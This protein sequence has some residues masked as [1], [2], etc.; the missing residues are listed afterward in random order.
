MLVLQ[1]FAEEDF[2][3]VSQRSGLLKPSYFLLRDQAIGAIVLLIRGTQTVKVGAVIHRHQG[4]HPC[5]GTGSVVY[6]RQLEGVMSACGS[7]RTT[8]NLQRTRSLPRRWWRVDATHFRSQRL[9]CAM[10]A[11]SIKL[12]V[13][14]S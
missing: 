13:Q 2:L 6:L 11:N 7:T 1:G 5:S 8:S 14:P 4:C 12:K 9:D 10:K 3:V